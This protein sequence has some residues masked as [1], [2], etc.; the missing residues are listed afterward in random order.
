MIRQIKKRDLLNE[1]LGVPDGIS[2]A[3]IMI[4]DKVISEIHDDY[5]FNDLSSI[6]DKIIQI[7]SDLQ[8]NDYKFLIF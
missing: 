7:N 6:T 2:E 1:V 4:Y 8:V 3:A 5:D